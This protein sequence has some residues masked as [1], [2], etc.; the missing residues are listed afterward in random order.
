MNFKQYF[1][2]LFHWFRCF[3]KWNVREHS[4]Y[5]PAGC[6]QYPCF[7]CDFVEIE[8]PEMLDDID[9]CEDEQQ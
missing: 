6:G 1:K 4:T 5:G 9:G 7:I 8:E 2:H 3:P